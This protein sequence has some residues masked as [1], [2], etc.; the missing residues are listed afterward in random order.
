M[1][2][3]ADDYEDS[4]D[5]EPASRPLPAEDRL[6]RHPSELG[7]YG[8]GPL[9]DPAAVRRHWLASQPSRASAW[10]AGLVGALLATGLVAL[11]THLASAITERFSP[12]GDAASGS[13]G[14]RAGG[15]AV[16]GRPADEIGATLAAEI[17][18]AG[19][20]VVYLDI[21]RGTTQLRCLG[22]GVRP[23]GMILAPAEDVAGATSVMVMLPDGTYYVG[24]VV[25]TDLAVRSASSGLALVHINGVS[26]LPVASLASQAPPGPRAIAV[27]LQD[28]GGASFT[29]GSLR[30]SGATTATGQTIL[31]DA[32]ETDLSTSDAPPGSA[33][34]GANGQL[35]G[36]VTGSVGGRALATPAWVAASVAAQLATRGSVSHGWLGI[37]GVTELGPPRGVQVTSVS[38][39]SAAQRSGVQTGDEIVS[40]DGHP[41]ASMTDLQGMLYFSPPGTRLS[42]GIVRDGQERVLEAV[43]GGQQ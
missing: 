28:P 16:P 27:A 12:P 31:V 40:V 13:T 7:R 8:T 42:V 1:A 22:V 18:S 23:D 29:V 4:S 30:T 14:G 20:A 17:A 21:S 34:L 3:Y 15:S 6:W 38:P 32:L 33:L 39:G 37:E 43:L 36:I 25:G 24:D 19:R 10:T 26:D 11:G 5:E 2:A 35:I 41:V 9:L